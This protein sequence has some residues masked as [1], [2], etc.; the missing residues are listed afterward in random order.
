MGA[1]LSITHSREEEEA[2]IPWEADLYSIGF[3]LGFKALISENWTLA[4][5]ASPHKTVGGQKEGDVAGISGQLA[6]GYRF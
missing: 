3:N 6:V 1:A 5:T 4:F 2:S